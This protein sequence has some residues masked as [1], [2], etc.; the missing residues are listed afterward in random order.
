MLFVGG[1][2]LDDQLTARD[3]DGERG[4]VLE[5]RRELPREAIDRRDEQRMCAR[6]RSRSCALPRPTRSASRRD[7]AAALR[8]RSQ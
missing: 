3:A 4:R 7:P 2:A 6:D 5:K 8:R 1:D